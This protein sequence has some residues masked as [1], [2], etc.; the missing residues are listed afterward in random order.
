MKK[1]FFPV[2][3]VPFWAICV[4]GLASLTGCG[5]PE[6]QTPI[7]PS[8]PQVETGEDPAAYEAGEKAIQ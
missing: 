6:A 1:L 8:T 7:D 3:V 4:I 5:G 2:I